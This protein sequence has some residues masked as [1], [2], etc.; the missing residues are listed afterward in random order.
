MT[1][2][3]WHRRLPVADLPSDTDVWGVDPEGTAALQI[4]IIP[5]NPGV[6]SYYLPFMTALQQHLDVPATIRTL[7]H[8]GQDTH[9]SG[10]GYSLQD[11]VQHKVQQ[12]CT[13]AAIH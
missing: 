12:Y 10:S 2:Q 1:A 3:V 9:S 8:A 7:S 11:Q 6:G 5:G 4:L 13:T